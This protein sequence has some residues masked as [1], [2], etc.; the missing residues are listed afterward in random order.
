MSDEKIYSL[1]VE[2]INVLN[3]IDEMIDSNS[4]K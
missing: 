4:M 2:L 3:N 1:I